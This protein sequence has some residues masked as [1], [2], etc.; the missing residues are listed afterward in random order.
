MY[1]NMHGWDLEDDA[2]PELRGNLDEPTILWPVD[3]WEQTCFKPYE[4]EEVRTVQRI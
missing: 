3:I 1:L 4:K 2:I